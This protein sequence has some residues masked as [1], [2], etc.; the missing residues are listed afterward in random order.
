MI[1]LA[2]GKRNKMATTPKTIAPRSRKKWREWLEKNHHRKLTI[3]VACSKKNAAKPAL[4][5]TDAVEEALCFGWIDAQTLSLDEDRFLQSFTKR[6]PQSVWSKSNKERVAKLISEGQMTPAGLESIEIAKNNGYW[7]IMDEVDALVIPEDLQKEFRRR[8][9]AKAWFS[10][11]SRSEKKLI[12]QSL[13]LAKRPETR[14]K[15]ISGI[16]PAKA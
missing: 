1:V 13:V 5:Y 8:P 9:A 4:A 2:L 7:S 11:L 3:W 10:G 14:R 16:G 15:R 12:L 6:K